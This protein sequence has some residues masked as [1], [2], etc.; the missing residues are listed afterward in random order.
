MRRLAF[1]VALAALVPAVTWAQ[2]P[3]AAQSARPPQRLQRADD[4]AKPA[5]EN[6]EVKVTEHEAKGADADIATAPVHEA[7]S[8]THHSVT[9]RRQASSPTRPPPAR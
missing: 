4:A 9:H 6:V 1:A 3:P 8:V 2:Q 7:A 5:Q